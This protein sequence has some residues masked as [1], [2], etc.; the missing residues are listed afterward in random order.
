MAD[1]DW[2]DVTSGSSSSPIS[3]L[4]GQTTP[5]P[6]L[7]IDLTKWA[8]RSNVPHKASGGVKATSPIDKAGGNMGAKGYE[9]DLTPAG[10]LDDAVRNEG[11]L[12]MKAKLEKKRQAVVNGASE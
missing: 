11:N 12:E 10:Q 9:V 2:D 7:G 1:P 6:A 5:P 8:S 4:V 3:S